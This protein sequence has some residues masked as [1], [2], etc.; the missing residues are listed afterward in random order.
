MNKFHPIK[1]LLCGIQGKYQLAV[2]RGI[3]PIFGRQIACLLRF[4]Q[5][6]TIQRPRT[7]MSERIRFAGFITQYGDKPADLIEINLALAVLAQ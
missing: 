7:F 4:Y 2:S 5:K 6:T 1:K 3:Q